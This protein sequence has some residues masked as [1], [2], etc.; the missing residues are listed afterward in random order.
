MPDAV[1]AYSWA[2][3]PLPYRMSLP[4]LEQ[5]PRDKLLDSIRGVS[6]NQIEETLSRVPDGY[7]TEKERELTCAFLKA[8]RDRVDELA[9]PW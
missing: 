4:G 7:M 8:R 6:D 2:V 1:E 3:M 9:T 5:E